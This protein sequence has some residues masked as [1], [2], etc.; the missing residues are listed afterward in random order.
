MASR[1]GGSE[2]S[3]VSPRS[4]GASSSHTLKGGVDFETPTCSLS[5]A[6]HLKALVDKEGPSDG[7]EL[8]ESDSES[9][10]REAI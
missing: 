6:S 10:T 3:L 5:I 8:R 9:A 7:V 4:L 1:D 2:G